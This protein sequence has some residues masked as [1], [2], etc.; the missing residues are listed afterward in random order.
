MPKNKEIL[1]ASDHAGYELKSFLQDYLKSKKY[2][3]F[4]CGTENAKDSVDYPDFA[5]KLCGYIKL[6]KAKQGI[7]ICGTGL[8]MS[9]SANKHSIIRAALCTSVEMAELS[10][11]HNDANV[12]VLGSRITTKENATKILDAFLSSKFEGGRH[13]KRIDKI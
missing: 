5:H 12:L 8:G 13:Q 10:K 1:I 6:N 3:V 4:D 11:Q 9:M 7:L 2:D